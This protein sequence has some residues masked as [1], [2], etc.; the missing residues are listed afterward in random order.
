MQCAPLAC[1]SSDFLKDATNRASFLIAVSVPECLK[2]ATNR[3][4]FLIASPRMSL[5]QVPGWNVE[6]IVFENS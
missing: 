3:A 4:G 5:L 1:H 6:P 2:D